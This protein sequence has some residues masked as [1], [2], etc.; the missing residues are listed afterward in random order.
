MQLGILCSRIRI[1]EKLLFAALDRCGHSWTRIDDSSQCRDLTEGTSSYDAILG[2][3][4]SHWN[5]EYLLTLFAAAGVRTVN[6]PGVVHICGDKLLTTS[7]LAAKGIPVPR[8]QIAFSPSAALQAAESLGYP[9][10]LK[11][12]IGSWGRLLAKLNDRDAVEAVI[13]HRQ[14]MRSPQHSIYY[15]QEYIEKPGRDLRILVAGDRVIAGIARV[16]GHWITNTARGGEPVAIVVDSDMERLAF[17]AS[18]A[19]GGG[20]LA[21]DLLERPCGEIVVNEINHT[22]EFHGAADATGLDIAG[23]IVDYFVEVARA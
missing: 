20:V 16:S 3:C 9:V 14:H 12:M 13:E 11:P 8:T 22:M 5:A 15:M 18:A 7:T 6:S 1:E 19:V 2:R 17:R 21:I 10:V 23:A 4:L